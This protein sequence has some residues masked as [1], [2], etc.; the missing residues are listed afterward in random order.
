MAPFPKI[1]HEQEPELPEISENDLKALLSDF[2]Y[3]YL[4][5]L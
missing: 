2:W 3:H 1:Q 5:N 4:V